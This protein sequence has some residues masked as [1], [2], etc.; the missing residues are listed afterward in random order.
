[1]GYH[2]D[3]LCKSC[4][5][6]RISVQ[7]GYLKP[8]FKCGTCGDVFSAGFDGAPYFEAAINKKPNET[9][10]D[11]VSHYYN[12][13]WVDGKHIQPSRRGKLVMNPKHRE[14]FKKWNVA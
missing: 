11:Y 10:L 12:G 4:K 13:S 5:R 14:W 1:M 7:V 9:P 6:G 3:S 2:K 8:E